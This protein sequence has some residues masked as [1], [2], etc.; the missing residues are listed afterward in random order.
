M[1]DREWLHAGHVASPHGLDGS[2]HVAGANP[3]LLIL[4]RA[5]MVGGT[6]RKIERRAGHDGGVILRLAGCADR[7]AAVALRGQEL[8]VARGHAPQLGE[9][10]WWAEDLEGCS[11]CDGDR[12][13]GI[14]TRLMAL[15]S[16]EVLEVKRSGGGGDLLVPMVGD[17]V[18]SVDLDRHVIDVDLRFLGEA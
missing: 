4:G 14:V 16:C 9:D 17:A 11:V 10:E 15:P 1:P 6:A 5:V 3:Q 7:D 13:V 8:L 12:E 2:F 18:R